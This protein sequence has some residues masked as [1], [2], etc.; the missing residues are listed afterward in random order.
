MSRGLFLW[1]R[2]LFKQLA[3]DGVSGS[4]S[5]SQIGSPNTKYNRVVGTVLTVYG[6]KSEANT[7]LFPRPTRLTAEPIRFTAVQ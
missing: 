6:P 1:Q 3:G 2:C 4:H 5:Q 7:L